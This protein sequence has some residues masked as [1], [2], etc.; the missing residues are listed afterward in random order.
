MT[1]VWR[2]V[3]DKTHLSIVNLKTIQNETLENILFSY[4]VRHALSQEVAHFVLTSVTSFLNQSIEAS[5]WL[6]KYLGH[7]KK[8][9]LNLIT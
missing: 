7:S 5:H 2:I 8:C 1:I 3:V 6:L 4:S 9:F